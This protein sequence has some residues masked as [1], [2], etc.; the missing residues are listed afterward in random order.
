MA[1][2]K[3]TRMYEGYIY[4]IYNDVND[5]VYIGQTT[6]TI[7]K[8]YKEHLILNDDCIIH[9]AINKYGK[10]HFN[11]SEVEKICCDTKEKLYDKLNIKEIEYITEYNSMQPNGYNITNGGNNISPKIMCKVKQYDKDTYELLNVFDS[12]S[13]AG[14][15]INDTRVAILGLISSCCKGKVKSVKGYVWR[16]FDDDLYKYDIHQK[17]K[18]FDKYDLD[19]NLL[20]EDLN[21]FE[22]RKILCR[23]DISGIYKNAIGETSSAYGYIWRFHGEA[24][25]SLSVDLRKNGNNLRSINC[26]SK[27]NIFIKTYIS[28]EEARLDIGLKRGS[29]ITDVC[30][31]RAKSAGGYVWYYANDLNQPD[32]SKIIN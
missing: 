5:K 32:K 11:V 24:F 12:I 2:N 23:K 7:E 18:S 20:I 21:A 29:H 3:K 31:G 28:S 4:K 8:R 1:Y 15:Y 30:K 19:G 10:K 16:Y 26:Y 17:S 13:E 25:G 27:D 14:A 22:I 9:K 6:R